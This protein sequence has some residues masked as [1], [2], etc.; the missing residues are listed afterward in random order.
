MKSRPG[1]L[2]ILEIHLCFYLPL[3]NDVKAAHGFW[4]RLKDE[5]LFD[6]LGDEVDLV[7]NV[8][9]SLPAVRV[10]R[11]LVELLAPMAAVQ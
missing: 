4:S 7:D 8:D 2:P 11:R 6:S 1:S 10:S 9:D 5:E 3:L